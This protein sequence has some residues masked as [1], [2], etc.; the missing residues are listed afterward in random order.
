MIKK[1]LFFLLLALIVIQFIHPKPNKSPG[2]QPN[3]LGK[4]Y[5][6]PADVESILKKACN[7]CH[8]NNTK[9]PWYSNIQPVDWWMD[10]HVKEGKKHLNLDDYTNRNLRYQYHKMEETIEMVKEG[11]MPLDSYTWMH[12][13][14]KLTEEEKNKL[15][16]WAG[17]VMTTMEAKYPIDSLKSKK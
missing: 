5:V 12:K 14:A 10:K 13:D 3:Y 2:D 16:D 17:S 9:Y 6:I 1:I 11:E 15:I 4:A 7:D 8:S